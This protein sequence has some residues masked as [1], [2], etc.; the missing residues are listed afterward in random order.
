MYLQDKGKVASGLGEGSQP[1]DM[2]SEQNTSMPL[3]T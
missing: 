1:A 2:V 3:I